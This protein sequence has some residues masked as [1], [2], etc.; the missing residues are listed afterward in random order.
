MRILG[1]I[2]TAFAA[3][4]SVQAEVSLAP[5]FTDHAVLQRG[6]PIPVWGWASPGESIT[7]KF[8]GESV[9]A[10]TNNEGQWR[11]DLPTLSAHSQG[12]TL[13]VTG[14]NKVQ[15][16]DI[17][18]GDVW[19]CGGQSNMEWV[20][21]NSRD[22]EQ[23]MADAKFPEIRHIKVAKNI[24]AEPITR[25]AGEWT[26]CSPETAGD[27]TAVGYFFARRLHRD[28]D[29]P[30]GLLNSNWG[31]TPVESW[32]PPDVMSDPDLAVTVAS[33]QAVI[34]EGI[35]AQNIAYRENLA[36]WHSA[37]A[38]AARKG[39]AFADKKPHMPWQ[40]G[41]FKTTSLLYNA[42]I[43]P[44]IPYGLAGFIWYQGE[45][46]ANQPE[47]YRDMFVALIESWRQKF[48]APSAP[49]YWAQLAS[50][51]SGGG[52]S[53]DWP[54][55]REAQHQTL[56]LPHTGQ[57]ILTDI[58]EAFDIHPK[59][60]QDVGDRLARIALAKHYIKDVVFRG[61]AH[62]STSFSGQQISVT[63]DHAKTLTTSD[64][65]APREFEIA[66]VDG[67][68]HSAEAT[69]EGT[70]VTLKSEA[71]PHPRDVRYAWH[72]WIE[73]NLQNP[74][75]LPAEPFRTDTL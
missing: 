11:V 58:G 55:L 18:V 21:R 49:F 73:P 39:E 14:K 1:L 37:Q 13:T 33:H 47:T 29:V 41:A 75:G 5:I 15:L 61:P 63:F 48:E 67:V 31:G 54:L 45:G 52:E 57:A 8:A 66:G 70:T 19:L 17:L 12:Q 28:L 10:V 27:Y 44:V 23:E 36:N 68:F 7:V 42:M 25:M 51:D 26:V 38:E 64:G 65:A 72:R 62:R 50:W 16:R 30:I 69:L 74:A 43:E 9:Q 35:L 3:L 46:N 32:L 71:V 56:K 40:P 6:K 53:L 59:N 2:F 20:V 4:I 60:K 34:N 22:A 24:A